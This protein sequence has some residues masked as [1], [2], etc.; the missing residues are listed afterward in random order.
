MNSEKAME[1]SRRELAQREDF[2]IRDLFNIL[3]IGNKRRLS[4]HCLSKLLN[5]LN[6][7]INDPNLVQKIFKLYDLDNDGLLNFTEFAQMIC[8][9]H[10]EFLKQLRERVPKTL[11]GCPYTINNV[12]NQ[13]I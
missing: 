12:L 10:T 7:K 9:R 11:P 6:F 5:Q 2:C 4:Y 1:S 8:P 13:I 3:D